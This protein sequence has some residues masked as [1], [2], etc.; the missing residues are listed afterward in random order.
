MRCLISISLF[1]AISLSFAYKYSQLLIFFPFG[2][3]IAV[4]VLR[5]CIHNRKNRR[6]KIHG[7][8]GSAMQQLFYRMRSP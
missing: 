1:I 3:G 7:G 2:S 4:E 8:T 6:P 5:L